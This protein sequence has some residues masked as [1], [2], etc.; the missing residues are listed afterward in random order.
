[1]RRGV[2][3]AVQRSELQLQ[4]SHQLSSRL[5]QQP[6]TPLSPHLTYLPLPAVLMS[7]S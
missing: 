5:L 3:V 4:S 6:L 1:M 7:S 2:V